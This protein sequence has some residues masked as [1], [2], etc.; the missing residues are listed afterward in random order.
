MA[1]LAFLDTSARVLQKRT[2]LLRDRGERR[3]LNP[4]ILT[5]VLG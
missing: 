4:E 3:T 5:T 1:V 2:A